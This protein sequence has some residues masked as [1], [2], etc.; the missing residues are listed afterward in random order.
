MS[1][2]KKKKKEEQQANGSIEH[3]P[4][5]SYDGAAADESAPIAEA[6]KART[7]AAPRK[8]ATKK[9][10]TPAAKKSATKRPAKRK[11]YEPTD[12]EIRLRAYFI[13]E[14]RARSS[15]IGD[16]AQDWLDAR[17]ELIEESGQS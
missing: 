1:K 16:P 15:Q 11:G 3:A 8:T 10:A 14:R 2:K 9:S 13:A 6:K 7:K 17:R 4:E 12:D 5:V